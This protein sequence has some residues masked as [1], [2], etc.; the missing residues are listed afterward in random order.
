MPAS[1]N[2]SLVVSVTPNFIELRM[3][4]SFV[5]V[6]M[7]VRTTHIHVWILD[8]NVGCIASVGF[9]QETHSNYEDGYK[10]S[11]RE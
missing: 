7:S 1:F 2:M 6:N 3:R 11:R 4:L 10:D 9:G 5:L 8:M